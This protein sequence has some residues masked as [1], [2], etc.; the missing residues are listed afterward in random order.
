MFG[1]IINIESAHTDDDLL[2]NFLGEHG[3]LMLTK[4]ACWKGRLVIV[5]D[6][7]IVFGYLPGVYYLSRRAMW[8]V[9]KS[10]S[11][12]VICLFHA[13]EKIDDGI[14]GGATDKS[15]GAEKESTKYG[16]KCLYRDGDG[17]G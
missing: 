10:A 14:A 8:M 5:I 11:F 16:G 15:I 13:R 1:F 6:L 9:A 7:A 2:E 17:S 4:H 3:A 12:S